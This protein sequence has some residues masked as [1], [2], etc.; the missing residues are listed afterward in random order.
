MASPTMEYEGMEALE[1]VSKPF[2]PETKTPNTNTKTNESKT[3]LLF[4]RHQ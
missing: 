2:H 1:T 3:A 4:I